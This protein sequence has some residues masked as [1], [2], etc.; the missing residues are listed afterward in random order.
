[1]LNAK[2][3]PG[4]DNLQDSP[5]ARWNIGTRMELKWLEL[6]FR[7]TQIMIKKMYD[8]HFNSS[9]FHFCGLARILEERGNKPYSM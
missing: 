5:W 3:I 6:V 9:N 1:M 7:G 4:S 8:G 2:C